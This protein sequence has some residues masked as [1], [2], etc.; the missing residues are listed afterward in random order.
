MPHSAARPACERG[1]TLVEALI[2]AVVLIAI[3]AVTIPFIREQREQERQRLQVVADT[4]PSEFFEF[5]AQPAKESFSIGEVIVIQC[6]I[7]NRADYTLTFPKVGVWTC[8]V[9]FRDAGFP[10]VAQTRLPTSIP[11]TPIGRGKSVKFEVRF[12][13]H[14]VSDGSRPVRVEILSTS[15]A[16]ETRF[17]SNEFRLVVEADDGSKLQNF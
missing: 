12:H 16:S 2:V 9:N 8:E 7:E 4:E 14:F 1:F 5:H 13:L 17:H 3:L 6:E 15:F 10:A 11:D